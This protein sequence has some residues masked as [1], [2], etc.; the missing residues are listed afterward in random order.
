MRERQ[1]EVG[2]RKHMARVQRHISSSDLMRFNNKP[3]QTLLDIQNV[4]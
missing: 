3:E 1:E 4:I 2:G